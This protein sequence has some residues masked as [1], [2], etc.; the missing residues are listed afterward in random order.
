MFNT[1]S[2]FSIFLTGLN[3][4]HMAAKGIKFYDDF[5]LQ[6]AKVLYDV[7]DNSGGFYKNLVEPKYRSRAN[8]TFV[9]GSSDPKMDAK[10]VEGAKKRGITEIKGHR[11]VGG[12]RASNYNGMPMEGIQ[13]LANYMKEFKDTYARAKL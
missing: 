12:F 10:F 9:T 1:P 8:I 3:L 11:S 4:K 7:I 2:T 5:S 6:K 13:A